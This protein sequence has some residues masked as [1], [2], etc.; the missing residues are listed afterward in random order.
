MNV[1]TSAGSCDAFDFGLFLQDRHFGF[2]VGRLDIG[3]K[4]P[5]ETR[6]ETLH[7]ARD[8]LR[9]AVARNHDLLLRVVE[10]VEGVEELFL[11]A[12]LRAER[13]NIVDQK[14]VGRSIAR[15]KFGHLAVLDSA[16]H[17][18]GEALARGVD[19]AGAATAD[20]RASDGVHQVRL[21]HADSAVEIE[22]VVAAR[23]ID[24]D[25]LC[26]RMCELIGRSDD[27]SAESKFRVQRYGRFDVMRRFGSAS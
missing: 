14:N 15:A 27:E 26:R 12:V 16:D 23:R 18:V 25:R 19:H 11:S 13:L 2:E 9:R 24:R 7:Q 17:F 6:A 1:H 22:R 4:T 20:Q 8:L 21:A 3:H 10:F 5:F